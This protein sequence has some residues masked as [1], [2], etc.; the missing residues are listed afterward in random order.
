[1]LRIN[2][3]VSAPGKQYSEDGDR[4]D[5]TRE[6]YDRYHE[7]SGRLTY[8]ALLALIGS[9]EYQGLDEKGQRKAAKKAIRDARE[10]ARGVLDDPDYP[11]PDKGAGGVGAGR[12][13]DGAPRKPPKGFPPPPPG[14]KLEGEAAGRNVYRDLQE[15]IPGVRFTSGF[16]DKAYQ[17]DMRAR[18]Y[19]PAQD[20]AHL[21]GSSFD[22]LPPPGKSMGWLKAQVK[23]YD[24][25]ARLLDE[26]DHLHA[27]F[28]GYY[29]APPVGGARSAGL[30]NPLAGI[31]PPP[32]GFTV[33]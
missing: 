7:I 15:A 12:E 23:R 9:A 10:T 2:K 29:G 4:L 1:M 33:N 6:Q 3:S 19:R 31:P 30:R 8:N 17:A 24:R 20:S 16:R 22:L 14:F 27:T 18:G 21:D 28:P 25:T 5:Y 26:G 32:P 13:D 11:L